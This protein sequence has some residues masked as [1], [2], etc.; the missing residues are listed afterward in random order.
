MVKLLH[1][2]V[3][4]PSMFADTNHWLSPCERCHIA[5]GDFTE[6]KTQQGNLIAHQPL[7][8]LCINF[9]KADVARGGKENILV[10]TDAFSKFSHGFVTSSQKSL[11]VAKLLV[12]KWFNI[13]GIP[14]QI[15]SDQGW[16]FNNEI[17]SQPCKMYSIWQ[18]TTTRYNAHGNALCKWFN[19]TLFGL[20]KTLTEE[21][22]LKWP[23]YLPS[24]VYTYNSTPHAS[25][26]FQP[27]KLMFGCKAPM[28]CNDW[29][30]LAHYKSDSFFMHAW[31]IK[32]LS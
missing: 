15:H 32:S 25:T 16:S 13:F 17:I 29:L 4:W 24:L 18:S 7:E 2:K 1:S 21:Q 28:P 14:A 20:M 26:G 5:K 12:E 11:F 22:M 8:L 3:Y 30:G 27:Y 6:P 19:H 31:P 9:T 23:V 10:L